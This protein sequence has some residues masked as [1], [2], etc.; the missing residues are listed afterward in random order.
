M[1]REETFVKPG[2]NGGIINIEQAY[3]HSCNIALNKIE[4]RRCSCCFRFLSFVYSS[5][6]SFINSL[7]HSVFSFLPFL[8]YS[9]QC[10]SCAVAAVV[11]DVVLT[12]LFTIR[13]EYI[14]CMHYRSY[15]LAVY[16]SFFLSFFHNKFPSLW[17][18]FRYLYISVC[19]CVCCI[20]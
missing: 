12:N 15:V 11:V 2:S 19:V 10:C 8:F 13:M 5:I 9:L 20:E 18:H 16:L 3:R 7:I 14:L 1:K 6:H 4:C 17:N